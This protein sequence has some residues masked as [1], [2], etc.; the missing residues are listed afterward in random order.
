M[1][2]DIPKIEDSKPNLSLKPKKRRRILWWFLGLLAVI[3][4]LVAG[5]CWWYF[6][7]F[8]PVSPSSQEVVRFVVKD[9][10]SLDNAVNQLES[11]GLIKNALAV[12]V[13]TRLNNMSKI[14]P[15]VYTF[16]KS[17]TPHQMLEKMQRG[18]SDEFSVTFKPGEN[19]Y[20]AK[21]VLLAAGYEEASI[22]A[23]FKKQYQKYSMM[24]G[25]PADSS[26]EG[27]IFGDTY[28]AVKNYTVENVLDRPFA[29]MQKYI[30]DEGLVKAFQ[31]RGL[32]LYEGIILASIIQREVSKPDDMALVSSVFHNRLKKKMQLGSDVTAAYGVQTLG[33]NT[34]V[35]EAVT[36]DTPYNTRIHTGLPPTPIASP[37]KQALR[38]AANPAESNYLY[39][40][41]GDDGKTYFATTNEQHEKNTREHCI[42]LC[43]L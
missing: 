27:F 12:I 38:A 37:G 35:V 11:E 8:K 19:I 5:A 10:S 43:K 42:E 14:F 36:V 39:F 16:S 6:E 26:I 32:T 24:L 28:N 41:A 25:R 34:S 23:A 2:I 20:D 29:L 9:G 18:T 22:D 15:G 21:K 1:D 4:A 17:Q 33:R 40:V 31:D 3:I 7:Q 13:H 30:D